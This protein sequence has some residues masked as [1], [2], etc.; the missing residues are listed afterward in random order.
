VRYQGIYCELLGNNSRHRSINYHHIG[1]TKTWYGAVGDDDEKLEAA[2]KT[3]APELFDQQPDLMWQ[4]VTLMSPGRLKKA[5][6]RVTACDQRPGEFVLTFPKAYH[7]ALR[8]PEVGLCY[9]HPVQL[10]SIRA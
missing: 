3:A 5:G 2:M 8:V 7:G 10:A 1:E 4:L 9:S 6:V